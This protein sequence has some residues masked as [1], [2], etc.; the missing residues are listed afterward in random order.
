TPAASS[1]TGRE[2]TRPSRTGLLFARREAKMLA[3]ERDHLRAVPF[4][5]SDLAA[6]LAPVTIDQQ[7]R[8][9]SHRTEVARCLAG[10]VDID[11]ERFEAEL[12][13]EL[14]DDGCALTVDRERQDKQLR[15]VD[16][17]LQPVERRHLLAA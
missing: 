9:N 2:P 12:F 14:L 1:S 3:N 6:D 13:I 4:G 17:G 8:R 15:F 10:L 7:C 5:R 11:A 16:R